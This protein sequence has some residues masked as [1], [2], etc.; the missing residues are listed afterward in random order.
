MVTGNLYRK[1]VTGFPRVGCIGFP[2]SRTSPPPVPLIQVHSMGDVPRK[3][4]V[5][6]IEIAGRGQ[7]KLDAVSVTVTP[8]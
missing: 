2:T 3:P 4:S 8:K 1:S 6:G 5:Q 7:S